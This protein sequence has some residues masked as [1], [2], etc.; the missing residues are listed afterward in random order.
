MDFVVKLMNK[1]EEK[2]SVVCVGLDPIL[3]KNKNDKGIIPT[4]LKY[5][6]SEILDEVAIL[7]FNEQ[8]ISEICDLV[9]V[10]KPNIAFYEQYGFSG[11]SALLQTI[12]F[13]HE[14][15]LLVILDSKRNDIG[16]TSEAYAKATF[17]FYKADACTLNGYLGWDSIK[18]YIDSYSD[19]GLFVLVKTSNPSSKDFQDLLSETRHSTTK[20]S[21]LM[22]GSID[23]NYNQ[24]AK[25]VDQWSKNYSSNKNYYHNLGMVVGAT[26]PEQLEDIRLKSKQ[27]F[28]LLPGYGTQGA[29]AEDVKWAFDKNGFGG[30]VNSSSGITYAYKNK[31]Y[32]ENEFVK[33]SEEEVIKMNLEINQIRFSNNN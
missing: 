31:N 29:K 2:N 12:K 13:A 4:Y 16:K 11:L 22:T 27:S 1:I 20:V 24:M 23:Y 10:V 25:L 26:F 21:G 6:V 28:I 8:I 15:G 17:D 7:N 18:P 5:D 14:K 3:P 30:I 19:K 9:P 33:A 32:N